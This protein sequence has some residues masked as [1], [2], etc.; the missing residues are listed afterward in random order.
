M[1]CVFV[2]V[3]LIN[4]TCFCLHGNHLQ[5]EETWKS[6]IY[7]K[8]TLK[9]TF[10]FYTTSVIHEPDSFAFQL[11]RGPCAMKGWTRMNSLFGDFFPLFFHASDPSENV[12]VHHSWA[13]GASEGGIKEGE[14]MR[15]HTACKE[16]R[17]SHS[18]GA[19]PLETPTVVFLQRLHPN[20]RDT[21]SSDHRLAIRGRELWSHFSSLLG[22]LRQK[23]AA[24]RN[25]SKSRAEHSAL[26]KSHSFHLLL[27]GSTW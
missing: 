12:P 7:P 10:K 3:S 24:C 17:H 26:V 22:A 20:N 27:S 2:P 14:I 13:C 16:F 9:Y 1:L 8:Q 4:I 5:F 19:L 23:T 15:A 25:T 18:V 11:E 6:A 21:P